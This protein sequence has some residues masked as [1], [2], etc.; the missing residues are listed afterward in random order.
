MDQ[1]NPGKRLLIVWHS[2]TNTAHALATAAATGA[3]AI[4]GRIAID[5]VTA[6]AVT[7]AM[8]LDASGYIFACP[9]NLGSMS[10]AMKEMV[11]RIYY[12]SLGHIA[13]RPYALI[14][15][16]GTDGEGTARQWQRV[17]TGWRLKAIADPLIVRTGADT[18]DAILAPKIVPQAQ[19]AA[20]HDLGQ[21]MAAG[22]MLGIF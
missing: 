12:P 20:A 21:V 7:G 3:A 10:G 15:A 14:I 2:R 13:G 4:D 11:D 5:M 1:N 6:D 16:A 8:M 9:E 17:A 22:L 19:L 18:A